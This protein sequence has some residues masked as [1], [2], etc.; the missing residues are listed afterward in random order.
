MEWIDMETGEG[1]KTKS[2]KGAR[3]ILLGKQIRTQGQKLMKLSPTLFSVYE[4]HVIDVTS[5]RE[6]TA[7][8][9]INFCQ[10]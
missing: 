10:S 6:E 8:V 1:R 2:G 3:W 9:S 5:V 4:N 7:P